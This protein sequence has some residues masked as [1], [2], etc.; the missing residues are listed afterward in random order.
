MYYKLCT[1]LHSRWFWFEIQLRSCQVKV[2]CHMPCKPCSW[3][4]DGNSKDKGYVRRLTQPSTGLRTCWFRCFS[5][6]FFREN[7][8]VP[9][10]FHWESACKRC[11]NMLEGLF[12]YFEINTETK[13]GTLK[14]PT[15][16]F[17]EH[18]GLWFSVCL[19]GVLHDVHRVAW[20][21]HRCKSL[22]TIMTRMSMSLHVLTV[23]TGLTLVL[24]TGVLLITQAAVPAFAEKLASGQVFL[25]ASGF[26]IF[27]YALRFVCSCRCTS[28][29]RWQWLHW[30][31]LWDVAHAGRRHWS[32][33]AKAK[34]NRWN[35]KRSAT[36]ESLPGV[37]YALSAL[38]TVSFIANRRHL[39]NR[40]PSTSP[41]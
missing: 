2:G 14:I 7:L 19:V 34:Q 36:S 25:L 32:F 23:R 33:T 9:C 41:F 39:R 5:C 24:I 10:F 40:R 4:S 22:W 38:G 20:L 6:L 21:G 8:S 35:W 3:R 29:W 18:R 37:V 15:E 31:S 26:E 13:F 1:M 16:V 12:L 30:Y 28:Q 11:L 17:L 27:H